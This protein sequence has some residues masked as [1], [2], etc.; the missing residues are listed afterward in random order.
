MSKVCGWFKKKLSVIHARFTVITLHRCSFL[1]N[2]GLA[3]G[4]KI[5]GTEKDLSRKDSLE[6]RFYYVLIE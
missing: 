6:S 2:S 4:G 1:C 3:L 5:C